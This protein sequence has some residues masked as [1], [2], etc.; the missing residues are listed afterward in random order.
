MG[1]RCTITFEDDNQQQHPVCLYL[2]WNGGLE[3]VLAF[4]S[5]TWDA[6]ERGRGDLYT[7]HARFCQV[8]GNYFPDGLCL[9]GHPEAEAGEWSTDNGHWHFR[10]GNDSFTLLNRAD[11]IPT[12][13]A[14]HYWTDSPSIFD[15]IKDAMAG[16]GYRPK[17]GG[18]A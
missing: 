11:E 5:Y 9:Y 7:F 2:Q 16:E 13:K 17:S 6:F 4:V 10:I 3:S 18:A 1:N 8:L 14:H 15:T 12:A